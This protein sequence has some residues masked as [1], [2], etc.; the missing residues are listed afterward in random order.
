MA[1]RR[2]LAVLVAATLM[3]VLCAVPALAQASGSN[4]VSGIANPQS[5][6][7]TTEPGQAGDV[8]RTFAEGN[9]ASFGDARSDSAQ[10][11][12][13]PCEFSG[14]PGPPGPFDPT[15]TPRKV[16]LA[17]RDRAGAW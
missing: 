2:K 15:L 5:G 9:K 14:E 3:L 12:S 6:F 11:R 4:C 1:S 13:G 10:D 16:R 8:N 7:G 17:V